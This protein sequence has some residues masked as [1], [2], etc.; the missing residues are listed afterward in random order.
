MVIC[1]NGDTK[2]PP[3]IA[4]ADFVSRS[5]LLEGQGDCRALF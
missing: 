2:V 5:N 4:T 3:A 1:S